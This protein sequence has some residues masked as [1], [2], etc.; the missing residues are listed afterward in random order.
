VKS[1]VIK[2]QSDAAL[3]KFTCQAC[4]NTTITN[5]DMT[6]CPHCGEKYEVESKKIKASLEASLDDSSCSKIKC[7]GC[8]SVLDVYSDKSSDELALSMYCPVCGSASLV[9]SDDS[10]SDSEENEN[11]NNDFDE[12]DSEDS[13]RSGSESE[14]SE[15]PKDTSATQ[16][17]QSQS[18]SQPDLKDVKISNYAGQPFNS[19]VC[20][21]GDCDQII[22]ADAELKKAKSN[23]IEEI[24]SDVAHVLDGE[25]ESEL[26]WRSVDDS[27]NGKNGTLVAFSAKT[28]LPL[29]VFKKSKCSKDIQS[30]FGSSAMISGFKQIA[31]SEGIGSAINK[32]GGQV[33]SNKLLEDSYIENRA[34]VKARTEILP[35]LIECMALAADGAVKGIYPDV[36]KD[37]NQALCNQLQGN[38]IP[39]DRIEAAVHN[40]LGSGAATVYASLLSKA[41]EL[42]NKPAPILEETKAMILTAS[43][44]SYSYKDPSVEEAKVKSVLNASNIQVTDPAISGLKSSIEVN[45][46]GNL[47]KRLGFGIHRY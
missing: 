15:E 30:M 39:K 13:E 12:S 17:Q 2:G 14:K 27:E 28:G 21:D 7:S 11:E 40:V 36:R 45:E 37:L 31:K 25:T 19:N 26:Q 29:F 44:P 20:Q 33:Y 23:K 38:G 32:F 22:S 35:K 3:G 46:V 18:Q 10:D 5:K 42:M 4:G 1:I 34:E 6:F 41:T 9:A 43:V 16:P 24:E 8:P 47:R